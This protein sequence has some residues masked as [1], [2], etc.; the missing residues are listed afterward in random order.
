M[1]KNTVEPDRPQK[2]QYGARALHGATHDYRHT[3]NVY[4][5]RVSTATMVT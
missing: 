4:T 2:T 1:K 5:C 3:Q